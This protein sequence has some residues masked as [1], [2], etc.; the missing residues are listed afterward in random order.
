MVISGVTGYTNTYAADKTKTTGKTG[1]DT[2]E[3]LSITSLVYGKS[4]SESGLDI[5]A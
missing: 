3:Y 4:G 1:S 5:R 2:Q